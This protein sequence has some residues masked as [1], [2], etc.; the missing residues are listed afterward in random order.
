M[1]FVKRDHAIST[2]FVFKL[3]RFVLT[4]EIFWLSIF[5]CDLVNLGLNKW[6]VHGVNP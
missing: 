2:L 4:V 5:D 6:R 3:S 1:N